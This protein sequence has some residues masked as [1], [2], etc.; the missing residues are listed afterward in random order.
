MLQ[1]LPQRLEAIIADHE[2]AWHRKGLTKLYIPKSNPRI[3][4]GRMAQEAALAVKQETAQK[5]NMVEFLLYT[6]VFLNLWLFC[7]RLILNSVNTIR[8]RFQSSRL[9]TMSY[10]MQP[11]P[12]LRVLLLGS[13]IPVDGRLVYQS[14]RLS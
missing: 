14:T 9:T 10:K 3:P 12:I 7:A 8:L 13:C 2:T 1:S 5:L 4:P 11:I 6:V